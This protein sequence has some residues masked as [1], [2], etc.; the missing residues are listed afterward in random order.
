MSTFIR[1]ALI[2]S[3]CLA[4]SH[5]IYAACGGS[6][7][8]LTS[9]SASVA[10][11]QACITAAATGATITVP[12][13]TFTWSSALSVSKGVKL[14]GAGTGNTNITC[15]GSCIYS[16]QGAGTNVRVSGFT[17]KNTSTGVDFIVMNGTGWRVDHN[18]FIASGNNEAVT[19]RSNVLGVHPSGL[20]DNNQINDAGV[21][22]LGTYAMLSENAMQSTLW[23][24]NPDIGGG[25]SAVYIE[26]NTF[27]KTTNGLTNAPDA[28]YGGRYVFRYNTVITQPGHDNAF[29]MEAHSSQEQGNRGTQR[30]EIYGNIINNQSSAVYFP[31]RLRGG[32]GLA[33]YN[34]IIGNW[35]NDAIAL[36]N[37]RS[38]ASAG[39]GGGMCNGSSAWDGNQDS[40]GW[41]CRDQIGRGY[42]SSF[43][44]YASPAPYLQVSMPVYGALNRSETNTELPFTVINSSGNAI[45]ANRDFYGYTASFNGTSGMGVGTLANRPA[46]CTK[47]VG[48]W[49]TDQSTT[50]LTGMVGAKPSTP[51][52]GTLYK[53]TAN[54]T[55]TAYYTPYT[56]PHPLQGGVIIPTPTPP[57]AP[58]NLRIL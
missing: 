37:V 36:D 24:Q 35:T 19:A 32:T 2:V 34:S 53:C 16:D 1:D 33:L 51:L 50:N 28:D 43:W 47:E 46:T 26:D 52:L 20:V 56:Y 42:D 3:A 8:N 17:F 30:W 25:N 55:W 6:G 15:S 23:A 5:N 13:G 38:Y 18:S 22:T 14:I 45:K 58:T 29:Y 40:T 57:A 54:N 12:S 49:A 31:F 27:T 41:P 39:L 7:A 9:S 10:D 11:I 4:F 21:L 44:N 48:Y